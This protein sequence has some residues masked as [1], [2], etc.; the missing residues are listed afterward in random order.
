[1]GGT[2]FVILTG[3]NSS[4][5]LSVV[6]IVTRLRAGRSDIQIS[7]MAREF[8]FKNVQTDSE[9]RAASY[10]VGTGVLPRG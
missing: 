9:A 1:M 10:S 3:R 7:I 2:T 5:R 4:S 6:H 8:F